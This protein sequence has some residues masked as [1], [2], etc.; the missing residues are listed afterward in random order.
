MLLYLREMN[1]S[2]VTSMIPTHLMYHR[3][4]IIPVVLLI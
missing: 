1:I 3:V 4:E 2:K